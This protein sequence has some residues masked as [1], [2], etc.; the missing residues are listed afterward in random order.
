MQ[1]GSKADKFPTP[2]TYS[3]PG[4]TRLHNR[5]DIFASTHSLPLATQIQKRAV[6]KQRQA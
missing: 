5:A 3:P 1:L 2:T 4:F 6:T